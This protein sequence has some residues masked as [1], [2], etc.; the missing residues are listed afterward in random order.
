MQI[1]CNLRVKFGPIWPLPKMGIILKFTG[2]GLF[3]IK[4]DYLYAG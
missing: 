1:V 2:T 4:M 3:L